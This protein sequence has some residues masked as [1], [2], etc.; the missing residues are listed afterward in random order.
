MPIVLIVIARTGR[1]SDIPYM[2]VYL[3]VISNGRYYVYA[4]KPS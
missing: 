1:R 2:G 3:V 4:A